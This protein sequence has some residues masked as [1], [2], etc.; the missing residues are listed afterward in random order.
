M[1]FRLG[2]DQKLGEGENQFISCHTIKEDYRG[3]RPALGYPENQDY[4]EKQILW[5][6]LEAEKYTGITL[7]ESYAMF[8]AASVSRCYFAHPQAKYFGVEKINKDQ[9]KAYAVRKQI[10]RSIAERWL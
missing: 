9:V 5:D 3:I 10:E 2:D 7:T 8:P 1:G 6:L 4:T